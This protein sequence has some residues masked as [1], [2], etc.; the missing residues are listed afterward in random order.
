MSQSMWC[1][2]LVRISRKLVLL[3]SLLSLS[4]PFA[5]HAPSFAKMVAAPRSEFLTTSCPSATTFGQGG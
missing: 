5:V 3:V 2:A 4:I 1:L